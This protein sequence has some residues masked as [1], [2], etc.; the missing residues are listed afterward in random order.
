MV[1][2][3]HFIQSRDLLRNLVERI[4]E[5][6]TVL[7]LGLLV[8]VGLNDGIVVLGDEHLD[9]VVQLV[10]VVD[11]AKDQVVAAVVNVQLLDDVLARQI[12]EAVHFVLFRNLVD[13]FGKGVE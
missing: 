4:L 9:L 13:V 7:A 11:H 8:R 5:Q 2:V 3:M 6:F 1:L 12:G 10:V